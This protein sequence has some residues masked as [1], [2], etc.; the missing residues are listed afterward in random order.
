MNFEIRSLKATEW[1][2]AMQLV[3]EI[4]NQYEAPE[5]SNEGIQSFRNFIEDPKLEKMFLSGQY[6]T[7][8]AFFGDELIGVIGIRNE[9]HVSLLFVKSEYH[10]QGVGR[11]LLNYAFD[12][13]HDFGIYTFTVNAAPYATDF[14]HK[15]GFKDMNKEISTD[16]IRFTPMK[17]Q[18]NN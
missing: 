15:I 12:Y 18:L 11:A 7:F 2:P 16:G 3:W 14:Y 8:G 6:Y 5:Y 13:I 1:K 9:N 10:R 4:F 17:I